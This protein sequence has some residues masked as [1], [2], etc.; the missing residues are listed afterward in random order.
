MPIVGPYAECPIL[1]ALDAK[2]ARDENQSGLLVVDPE[3]IISD[4]LCFEFTEARFAMS[5]PS[6]RLRPVWGCL[7]NVLQHVVAMF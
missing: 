5:S 6:F 4:A 7:A 1:S 2:A 3:T